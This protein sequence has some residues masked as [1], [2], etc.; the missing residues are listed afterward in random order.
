MS[1]RHTPQMA[2]GLLQAG[3]ATYEAAALTLLWQAPVDT[4]CLGVLDYTVQA[5]LAP[6]GDDC[7]WADL[8]TGIQG[9][10]ARV[11]DDQ[12][13]VAGGADAFVVPG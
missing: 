13:A 1:T 3:E 11:A 10:A 12:D 9:E 4:G 8:A 6:D 2:I 7:C 5:T